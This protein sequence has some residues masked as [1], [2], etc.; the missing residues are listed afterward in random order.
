MSDISTY[1]SGGLLLYFIFSIG[2][3]WAYAKTRVYPLYVLKIFW[4]SGTILGFV[5]ILSM[6]CS[7]PGPRHGGIVQEFMK[8]PAGPFSVVG[9]YPEAVRSMYGMGFW[10]MVFSFIL[11]ILWRGLVAKQDPMR[12][13]WPTLRARRI[14]LSWTAVLMAALILYGDRGAAGLWARYGGI[15]AFAIL[16]CGWLAVPVRIR[17]AC[18]SAGLAVLALLLVIPM[19]SALMEFDWSR[20]TYAARN[21]TF[22]WETAR[23]GDYALNS[24]MVSVLTVGLT[25]LAGSMAAYALTRFDAVG[26]NAVLFMFIGAMVIPAQ[27]Y[28]V[29]LFLMVQDWKFAMGGVQ[30]SFMDSRLGLSLIY[31]AG[32]LPFAI[33]LLTG[34]FRTL[35]SALGEVAAIDGCG[36]WRLFTDVYFPL[37][38][39]G[40]V[41]AAIFQF[42]GVWNEY[43]FAL[44]FLTN[45]KLKTLPVGLYNLSVS[46]KYAANW[47]ALFAGVTILCI[48]TF[49]IFIILQERIVA[50]MTVGAVKE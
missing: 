1:L 39:P 34:F 2:L 4:I 26:R 28:I 31:A 22:A 18:T 38:M 32:G 27:L 46:Q 19:V 15:A 20:Y 40:L 9:A 35:P 41:T 45:D 44:V 49:L 10:W 17:R 36:E 29:P 48:P 5:W 7:D 42:L 14:F 37:A 50:G 43:Q 13:E 21:Y 16:V 30:F 33:F 11:L 47:P 8:N 24:L 12:D 6:S 3:L 23:M 25:T